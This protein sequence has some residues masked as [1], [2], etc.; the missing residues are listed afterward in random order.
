MI[1]KVIFKATALFLTFVLLANN[2]NNVVIVTDF[3]IN[4]D[5][6]AKTLCIQKDDQKGCNGKCQLTKELV[7]NNSDSNSETPLPS[8]DRTR[9]DVFVVYAKANYTIEADFQVSTIQNTIDYR[10]NTPTSGFYAI[11]TPP[12]NLS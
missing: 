10:L 11:D 2:I 3:V 7:Q 6:I 5:F 9:L 12:P 4:Q 8:T 1:I